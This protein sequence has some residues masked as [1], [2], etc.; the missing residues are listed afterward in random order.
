MR[1]AKWGCCKRGVCEFEYDNIMHNL[2]ACLVTVYVNKKVVEL[3]SPRPCGVL[4]L[5]IDG[6]TQVMLGLAILGGILHNREAVF[7]YVLQACRAQ[8]I[9]WGGHVGYS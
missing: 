2:E 7:V 3:W 1:I 6:A 4:K 9:E 8:G 5:D